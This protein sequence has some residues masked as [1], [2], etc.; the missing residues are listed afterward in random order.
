MHGKTLARG[1][2]AVALTV[3]AVTRGSGETMTITTPG[4]GSVTVPTGYEWTNV[5]VQCWSGG[6]GGGGFGYFNEFGNG[7]YGGD[8]G[9]GGAYAYNSY[10]T[11]LSGSYNYYIGAGGAAGAGGWGMLGNG[12][13]GGNT[14]WNV[15]VH[16]GHDRLGRD[17]VMPC[18]ARWVDGVGRGPE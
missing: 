15:R 12:S 3:F 13:P 16:C 8:G 9:G 6:G 4:T 18:S 5:T 2:L 17:G 1:L 14:I 11:L 10:A 7:P